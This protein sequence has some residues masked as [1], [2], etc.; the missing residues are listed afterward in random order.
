M[1]LWLLNVAK[2]V[3]HIIVSRQIDEHVGTTIF[4]VT[5]FVL[6]L[7]PVGAFHIFLVGKLDHQKVERYSS[8]QAYLNDYLEKTASESYL[9][10]G[11]LCLS[12]ITACL[13]DDKVILHDS[14]E[15]PTEQVLIAVVIAAAWVKQSNRYITLFFLAA[16]AGCQV[17]LHR[18]KILKDSNQVDVALQKYSLQFTANLVLTAS[19]FL[20]SLRVT[21]Y[22][23]HRACLHCIHEESDCET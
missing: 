19:V 13:Q 17:L 14:F 20:V 1:C 5:V 12:M 3:N 18:N 16:L 21:K 9:A 7:Q 8:S 10:V 2:L 23:V 11:L 6:I 4:I 22:F 15:L